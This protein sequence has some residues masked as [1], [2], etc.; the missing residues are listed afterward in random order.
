MSQVKFMLETSKQSLQVITKV[1]LEILLLLY[2]TGVVPKS[3]PVGSKDLPAYNLEAANNKLLTTFKERIMGKRPLMLAIVITFWLAEYYFVADGWWHQRHFWLFV[4][5]IFALNYECFRLKILPNRSVWPI[6]TLLVFQLI[7]CVWAASLDT[8]LISL[9]VDFIS[10]LLLSASIILVGSYFS[11]GSILFPVMSIG[12][13]CTF[14]SL[15]AYYYG[16]PF[17]RRFWFPFIYENGLNPVLTGFICGFSALIASYQVAL[18]EHGRRKAWI[19]VA[20]IISFMGLLAAQ[21]RGPW[22]AFS[23]GFAIM[24][25]FLRRR[26]IFSMLLIGTTTAVYFTSLMSSSRVWNGS[27]LVNRGVTG[28]FDIYQ[29][30]LDLMEPIHLFIGSGWGTISTL[31]TEKLGWFVH[32][33]HSAYFTQFYLTG[34]IGL[35]LLLLI[36]MQGVRNG[37]YLLRKEND[38]LGLALLL[39]GMVG[40]LFDGGHIFSLLSVS[41]IEFL[42]VAAPLLLMIGARMRLNQEATQTACSESHVTKMSPVVADVND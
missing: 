1:V 7:S 10:V 32:H 30:Y 35:V 34:A 25:L 37:V 27:S 36:L 28:R 39:S 4:M 14:V 6:Y 17:S 19:A 18:E 12:A 31:P 26:V 9:G 15:V 20:L 41:R 8:A 2:K 22:L 42:L 5:P 38:G 16:H 21:S 23:V 33:P 24:T 29:A 13:V 11:I 40:V 3:I